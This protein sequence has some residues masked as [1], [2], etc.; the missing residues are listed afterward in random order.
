[1]YGHKL[2]VHFAD[3]ELLLLAPKLPA[4]RSRVSDAVIEA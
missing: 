4:L 3:S 2:L 1:M